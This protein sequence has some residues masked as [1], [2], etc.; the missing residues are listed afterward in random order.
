MAEQT[1]AAKHKAAAKANAI[2]KADMNGPEIALGKKVGACSTPKVAGDK[3]LASEPI[4]CRIVFM[5][6][7][8][9]KAAKSALDAGTWLNAATTCADAPELATAFESAVGNE[10]FSEMMIMAKNI[11]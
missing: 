4:D 7:Y 9:R 6:L 2:V 1:A 8:P 10:A 5:G 11:A 3:L